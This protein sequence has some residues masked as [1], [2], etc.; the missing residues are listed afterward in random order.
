VLASLCF[1]LEMADIALMAL[2][3]MAGMTCNE[4]PCSSWEQLGRARETNCFQDKMS[5]SQERDLLS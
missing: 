5:G 4:Y 3:A 2:W 1:I